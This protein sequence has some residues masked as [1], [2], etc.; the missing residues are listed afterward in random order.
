MSQSQSRIN[1]FAVKLENSLLWS[2]L[3]MSFFYEI[4][5]IY[6]LVHIFKHI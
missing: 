2:F 4:C 5:R 6:S 3:A 1:T